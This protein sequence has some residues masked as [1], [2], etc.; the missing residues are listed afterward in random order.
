LR[1]HRELTS[2]AEQALHRIARAAGFTL[3]PGSTMQG[4]R[5]QFDENCSQ[6]ED[7]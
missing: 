6:P 5:K 1:Y 3:V 4:R 7:S 2:L